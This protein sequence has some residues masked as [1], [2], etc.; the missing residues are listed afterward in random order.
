MPGLLFTDI[1]GKGV[2]DI[3]RR[4]LA[5]E[6]RQENGKVSN[7]DSILVTKV[8]EQLLS[9]QTRPREMRPSPMV[10]TIHHG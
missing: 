3:I 10:F 6:A 2:A 8:N 4:P 5:E 9:S 1:R 7:V